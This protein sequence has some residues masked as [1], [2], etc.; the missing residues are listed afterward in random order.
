[1]FFIGYLYVVSEFSLV[2]KVFR[3]LGRGVEED[4]TFCSFDDCEQA[5]QSWMREKL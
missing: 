1:M 3:L 2:I 5:Y 4:M